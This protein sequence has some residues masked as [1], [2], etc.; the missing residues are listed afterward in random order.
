[1]SCTALERPNPVT[2]EDRRRLLVGEERI[3]ANSTV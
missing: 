2:V 3:M 1:M